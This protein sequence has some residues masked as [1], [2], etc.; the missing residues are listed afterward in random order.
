MSIAS[1]DFTNRAT[2][3]GVPEND[4]QS[5]DRVAKLDKDEIRQIPKLNLAPILDDEEIH[6]SRNN[7]HKSVDTVSKF[8]A[9]NPESNSTSIPKN[10]NPDEILSPAY[11]IFPGRIKSKDDS[12]M[13]STLESQPTVSPT[14]NLRP[15]VS[16]SS[17]APP[18]KSSKSGISSPASLFIPQSNFA[19]QSHQKIRTASIGQDAF[20]PLSPTKQSIVSP[21]GFFSIVGKSAAGRPMKSQAIKEEKDSDDESIFIPEK[22]PSQVAAA[23]T[24]EKSKQK[25][26]GGQKK[27]KRAK[28]KTCDC[29][30]NVSQTLKIVVTTILFFGIVV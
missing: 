5:P 23:H 28:N 22:L 1:T 7:S 12:A 16:P 18:S 24:A 9:P 2:I 11:T 26:A 4:F 19:D 20:T 25:R 14:S 17:I 27:R 8:Q 15:S 30:P 21:S 29:F 13:S 10:N 3:I 6:E